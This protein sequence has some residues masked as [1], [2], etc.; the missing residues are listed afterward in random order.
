MVPADKAISHGNGA[1]PW[2][3]A[4][5]WYRRQGFRTKILVNF[6]PIVVVVAI[7]I[8]T[9]LIVQQRWMAYRS[10]EKQGSS[11]AEYLSHLG[12]LSVYGGDAAGLRATLADFTADRTVYWSA[13]YNDEGRM[14]ADYPARELTGI[15]LDTAAARRTLRLSHQ[16]NKLRGFIQPIYATVATGDGLFEEGAESG[17][18]LIGYAV[19]ALSTREADAATL[20][21]ISFSLASALLFIVIGYVL[22]QFLAS[23]IT[24]SLGRLTEGAKALRQGRLD[25]RIEVADQD[26][27]RSL[28]DS[29]NEMALALKTDIAEIEQMAASLSRLNRELEDKVRQRTRQLEEANRHKSAF[30]ANMSHEL[31]TPL[32]SIIGFASLLLDR[33]DGDVNPD[34]EES[35]EK[36]VRNSHHLLQLIN[37]VLDLSKIE[38]GKMEFRPEE[39]DFRDALQGVINIVAP[40]AREKPGLSLTTAIPP[41]FP[42]AIWAD[43]QKFKQILMNLLTNAIKYSEHGT[44]EVAAAEEPDRVVVS[45]S[46]QGI[47]IKPEQLPDVFKEFQ[48][49]EKPMGMAYDSIGLGLA[50]S[51]R[52]VQLHGGD[53]WVESEPG[54]GSRFTFTLRKRPAVA[55]GTLA[56]PAPDARN[57]VLVVDDDENIIEM[58]AKYLAKDGFTA[59]PVRTGGEVVARAKEV[60]PCAITLDVFLPDTN[61]WEVLQ[62]IKNDPET[63]SI[64]V[65]MV[66]I[67]DEQGLGY[68]LGAIDY[69]VKPLDFNVLLGRLRSL[70]IGDIL[71]IEYD[72][73]ELEKQSDALE[74]AGY[75][76]VAAGS[77]GEALQRLRERK[78]GL[79]V[80]SMEVLEVE[81]MESLDILRQDERLGQTPIMLL[82]KRELSELEREQLKGNILH[83]MQRRTYQREDLLSS[84]SRTVT[85]LGG[86]SGKEAGA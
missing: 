27:I 30:L 8:P 56:A 65:I 6:L 55:G 40:L 50:I 63:S 25:S 28:A 84:I 32:N 21:A 5:R 44:I 51:K 23:R 48:Q 11:L 14:L 29:F 13:V 22:V 71:L 45:V 69:F 67:V 33:V 52:L 49:L 60:R 64:P 57:K 2:R 77:V 85:E 62:R 74:R 82:T 81:G 31:R 61:G 68:S 76:V 43:R 41:D 53:I 26:E 59:V 36:I 18:Q 1:G 39:F 20:R 42:G 10:L 35:L 4:L 86:R 72:P 3:A 75:K 78:P 12:R 70:D 9:I 7:I 47:G 54:R 80:L 17:R 73:G 83:I 34:Q 38:A 24:G 15:V 79:I 66:S 16:G 19:V 58:M 37:E 46:D